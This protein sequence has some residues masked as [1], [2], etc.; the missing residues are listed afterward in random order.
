MRLE[1]DDIDCGAAAH[2]GE[3][4][5]FRVLD[6]E[7]FIL[8]LLAIDGFATSSYNKNG[9]EIKVGNRH[10]IIERA[11]KLTI[12][13]SEIATLDHKSADTGTEGTLRS[14]Y[15]S[16][17]M[18]QSCAHFLMIRWKPLSLYH[19]G[20]PDWPMPFSPVQSAPVRMG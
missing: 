2:H 10:P 9:P 16:L 13:S 3:K 4:E 18:W 8:E 19:R 1:S 12:S 5:R 11:T 7:G 14:N 15:R 17:F 20:F 6:G